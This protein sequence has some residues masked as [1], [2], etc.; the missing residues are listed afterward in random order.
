[1]G[2]SANASAYAPS[3]AP[4]KSNDKKSSPGEQLEAPAPSKV[5]GE[6]QSVNSHG[7]AGS[8]ASF[9]SECAVAGSASSGPGLSPSSSV[10]SLSS[11]RSTLKPHAKVHLILWVFVII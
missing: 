11:E 6:P 1:M 3:H 8:S 5:P 2:L 9:N 7:R 4:L 10:G